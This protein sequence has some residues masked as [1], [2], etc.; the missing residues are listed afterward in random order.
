MPTTEC[1]SS[2]G[3]STFSKLFN[4]ISLCDVLY[5]THLLI[6]YLLKCTAKNDN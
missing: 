6:K 1:N 3:I 2:F 5:S 4:V